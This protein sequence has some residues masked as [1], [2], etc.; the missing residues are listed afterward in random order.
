MKF[1]V[2][3]AGIDIAGQFVEKFPIECMP[4][5]AWVE[6][7]WVETDD[8]CLEPVGHHVAGK[9]GSLP[10]PKREDAG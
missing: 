1:T 6:P 7:L 4:R 8:P 5:K 3:T 9:P 2:F 10:P